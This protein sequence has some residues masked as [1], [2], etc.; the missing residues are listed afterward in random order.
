MKTK[1]KKKAALVLSGGGARGI[2]HIGVIEEL[3]KRD[4]EI[5]SIAGTSMGALVGGIYASGGLDI[6]GHWLATLNKYMVF[7]LMDFTLSKDGI[8]KGNK[9]LNEIKK[10]VPDKNIEECM[11]PF[12]AIATDILTRKEVVFDRGSLYDAIRAS[13]SLPS[14]FRPYKI[15]DMVLIDGGVVNQLPVDRVKR[16]EGD[17]LIAVNVGADIPL[18]KKEIKKEEELEEKEEALLDKLKHFYSQP[19]A[20]QKKEEVNY[21]KLL[22]FSTSIM[23]HRIIELNMKLFPPDILIEIPIDSY[24]VLE[25]YKA[26]EIRQLGAEVASKSL[27]K[28]GYTL[29]SINI[30]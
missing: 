5:C 16:T 2:A 22:S 10:L 15:N 8:M 30:S 4:F 27:D 6:F 24:N 29:K 17:I 20:Y 23:I 25:F 9:V 18:E 19:F 12:T 14:L 13:I 7:S 28:L 11:I 3:E 1:M 21:Y 26:E